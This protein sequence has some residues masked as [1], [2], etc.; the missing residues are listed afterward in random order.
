[1]I[2]YAGY[3]SAALCLLYYG[4]V[5]VITKRVTG[6]QLLW[7]FLA[8]FF[9]LFSYLYQRRKRGKKSFRGERV[10][11]WACAASLALGMMMFTAAEAAILSAMAHQPQPNADYVIVLG[12]KVNKTV[13]SLSLRYRIERAAE[14]LKENPQSKAILSGGQGSDEDISEAEA[15]ALALMKQGIS[16]ERILLESRSTNTMENLKLSMALIKSDGGSADSSVVIVTSDF[17]VFRA[18]RFA[19]KVGYRNVS[20]CAA[21][22][23]KALAFQ[24]HLREALAVSYYFAVG[25]LG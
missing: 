9:A 16:K 2:I 7:L 19:E 11:F 5:C 8:L 14:Y 23:M 1:M 21:L 4:M 3:V 13:P 17:H 18:M 25:E 15:M 24:N 12:A 20:G 22:S 10:V 6:M